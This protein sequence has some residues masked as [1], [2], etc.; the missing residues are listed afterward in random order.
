MAKSV[1]DYLKTFVLRQINNAS[2][3]K[4]QILLFTSIMFYLGRISESTWKEMVIILLGIR[5]AS[6][7]ASIM[8]QNKNENKIN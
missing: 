6:D 5:G 4:I 7:V 8:K 2:S 3:V 1:T